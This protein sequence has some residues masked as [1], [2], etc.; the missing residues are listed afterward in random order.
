MP[1]RRLLFFAPIAALVLLCSGV[2]KS[3][4]ADAGAAFDPDRYLSHI[5]YLA[6]PELKG[7]ESGSPEL[8]KAAQYIAGQ[9]RADGLRPV[10]GKNFEQAFEITTSA[11]MGKDNRFEFSVGSDRQNLQVNK[12]FIPFN[13]SAK[14][15]A[16]AK[17]VFAGYGITAPEYNYDDYAGIDA[18][19][20]LV[21]VLAHEPQ[22]YDEKSVFEGKVY[23][24]HAQYY[25]K[26][27]NARRH[28]AAGVILVA[29]RINHKNSGDELEL[30]GKTTGPNDAGILFV[31]V[32]EDVVESWFRAG[33]KNLQQLEADIDKDLKPRSFDLPNMEVRETV[34]VERAIRTVHNVLGYLPGQTDEFVIIGAHYDHLGLGEQ[35]SL[36]PSLAGTV[37][38]GADDNASG[39]AGVLELAHHFTAVYPLSGAMKPKRG[40]LFMT[41]AGEELGLLG[42]GYF[43]NHPELPLNK[44]AV[45]INMDMIG[46]VKDGK[47]YV[48]GAGTGTTLRADVDALAARSGLKV[49]DSDSGGSGGYGS[50]DHISFIAKQV[51]SLFFFSGLHG[52][53]HKPS[54]TWDKINAPGAIQVLQLVADITERVDA[55]G[56]RPQF[57]R[58]EPKDNPHGGSMEPP[59]TSSGGYGPYFGSIPDF[60]EVPRG[61]RF[62]DITPGSPAALGGLKAGDILVKFGTDPI[63]NLYD[64]TYALRAHK[65]GEE[66]EVEVLR[67]DKS[68]TAKV[69]LTERR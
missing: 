63:R 26:A 20:K 41:F 13:F 12:E 57:V 25:S 38:P 1:K 6:S 51:P 11:K 3:V 58:I 36:A 30:F 9:F 35:F 66:V 29:D 59:G 8:E 52:D 69:K 10:D 50:S 19:G 42:S 45:M 28:G 55:Q 32:K 49:D 53:Y 14:G 21:V 27:A 7:R 40:I 61:V 24:D 46:R 67:N 44:A 60:A 62:A 4:G 43:A 16:S 56:D 31:Q 64:F 68:V 48:G 65:P 54:D 23:T 2:G 15:K 39:T 17:V 18:K 5:K 47:L 22:E 37:H 34:D 33:G